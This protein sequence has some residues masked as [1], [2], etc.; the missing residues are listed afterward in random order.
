MF[1]LGF[2]LTLSSDFMYHLSLAQA[3]AVTNLLLQIQAKLELK[4]FCFSLEH[5]LQI[6]SCSC[7]GKVR[8]QV[9]FTFLSVVMLSFFRTDRLNEKRSYYIQAALNFDGKEKQFADC[10][11]LESRRQYFCYFLEVVSLSLYQTLILDHFMFL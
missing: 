7:P 9:S 6:V 4:Q 11:A 1:R 2:K 5:S 8:L 3:M 10:L